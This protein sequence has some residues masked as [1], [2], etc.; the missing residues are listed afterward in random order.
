MSTAEMS[1][2]S[3]ESSDLLEN[4][5]DEL[6]F[7]DLWKLKRFRCC[8]CNKIALCHSFANCG[9]V[10]CKSCYGNLLDKPCPACE[11]IITEKHDDSYFKRELLQL[12]VECQNKTQGCQE[13]VTLAN[14]MKHNDE[15]SY[16]SMST[17]ATLRQLNVLKA[18]LTS[19]QD[20][21]IES[22][23]NEL[24]GKFAKLETTVL[25]IQA[26]MLALQQLKS[27]IN[28]IQNLFQ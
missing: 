11:S 23:F 21:N 20:L 16:S 26:N 2:V 19:Y 25:E 12:K 7:V 8:H 13:I 28:N 6:V 1:P 24:I 15:C 27:P 10:F 22:K 18:Q 9:D 17:F 14:Y 3:A 4:V 5:I